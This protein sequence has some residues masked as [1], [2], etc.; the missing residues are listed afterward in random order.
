MTSDGVSPTWAKVAA[1]VDVFAPTTEASLLAVAEEASVDAIAHAVVQTRI[2]SART[3]QLAAVAV[4]SRSAPTDV[5]GVSDVATDAIILA[6][7]RR[8]RV[9]AGAVAPVEAIVTE[10]VVVTV[11]GH[12]ATV[13][14]VPTGT[15]NAAIDGVALVPGEPPSTLASLFALLSYHTDTLVLTPQE[16]DAR[17]HMLAAIAEITLCACA[18]SSSG[19]GDSCSAVLAVHFRGIVLRLTFLCAVVRWFAAI[20]TDLCR[21]H[22]TTPVTLWTRASGAIFCASCAATRVFKSKR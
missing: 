9:V 7:R 18:A 16:S 17:A 21:G 10:T 13:T 8:A 3:V 5:V 14:S 11:G 15:G 22:V 19:F 4:K 1:E 6:G 2:V 12:V 20:T